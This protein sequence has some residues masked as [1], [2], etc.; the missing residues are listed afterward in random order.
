MKCS[1]PLSLLWT[2]RASCSIDNSLK[3]SKKTKKTEMS[4]VCACSTYFF[5]NSCLCPA[6]PSCVYFRA[7]LSSCNVTIALKRLLLC[8]STLHLPNGSDWGSKIRTIEDFRSHSFVP[9]LLRRP[10]LTTEAKASARIN[11]PLQ[12]FTSACVSFLCVCVTVRVSW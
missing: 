7:L 9:E 8:G 5:Q 11:T 6:V 3:K 4:D 1:H 12:E 10:H 2:H